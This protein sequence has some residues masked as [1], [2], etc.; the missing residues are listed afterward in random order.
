[1][2]EFGRDAQTIPAVQR[3]HRGLPGLPDLPGGAQ[4]V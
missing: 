1:M 3:G 4:P 2:H